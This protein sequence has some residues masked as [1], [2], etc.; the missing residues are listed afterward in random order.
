MADEGDLRTVGGWCHVQY[1]TDLSLR[2]A[3]DI[4]GAVEIGDLETVLSLDVA[5]PHP[6]TSLAKNARFTD[7]DP[8]CCRKGS[9]RAG[10]V[11]EE[12]GSSPPL[13][14]GSVAAVVGDDGLQTVGGVQW[15]TLGC[16]DTKIDL[17]TLR[18]GVEAS[19]CPERTVSVVDDR[20]S[21][22]TR[23]ANVTLILAV[24]GV[25][26][27]VMALTVNRPELGLGARAVVFT[28]VG[29]EEESTVDPANAVT[30]SGGVST[31]VVVVAVPQH[32]QEAAHP[33]RTQPDLGGRATP[34]ALPARA[35]SGVRGDDGD[36][37]VR[38]HGQVH[39]WPV[40]KTLDVAVQ[41]HRVQP[42]QTDVIGL[43][44]RRE[45]H[46]L[47]VL[48]SH[49]EVASSSQP[50]QPA[51][52]AR[53]QV[54]DED[55]GSLTQVRGPRNLRAV[56]TKT[57]ITDHDVIAGEPTCPSSKDGDQPQVVVSSENHEVTVDI[58][59]SQI[60]GC[61]RCQGTVLSGEQQEE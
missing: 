38:V 48:P 61:H 28:H 36:S 3:M 26:T 50:G 54:D 29:T 33:S 47:V 20:P 42:G 19:H 53:G 52:V 24:M 23:V 10:A 31:V 57:R 1:T 46:V 59:V 14:Q 60:S 22:S 9:S 45:H 39:S 4:A 37:T 34:I 6:L 13:Q 44:R 21:I 43:M 17:E 8:V 18:L 51:L 11:G 15:N 30:S 58:G 12:V 35:V 2:H 32:A 25:L 27:Q 56:R 5:G 16:S 55:F 7:P 49:H 41:G 40:S